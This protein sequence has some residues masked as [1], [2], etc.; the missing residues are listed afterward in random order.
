MQRQKQGHF[1]VVAPKTGFYKLC[2]SNR[3]SSLS[4]KT[5]AFTTHVGDDL[6]REIAKQDHITPLENELTQLGDAIAAVEDEQR[7]MWNR[8]RQT[9]DS[10]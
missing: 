3:M 2:F 8:E 1:T 7:Y 10:E 5:V 9:R 6:Y 4:D